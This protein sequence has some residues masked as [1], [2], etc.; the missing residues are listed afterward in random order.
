MTARFHLLREHRV[1]GTITGVERVRTLASLD[2]HLDR[3][4]VSYKDAKVLS[5]VNCMSYV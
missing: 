5:V 3:L 1:H 4:I 2:D